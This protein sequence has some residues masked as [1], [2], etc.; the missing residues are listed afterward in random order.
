MCFES[1]GVIYTLALPRSLKFP[2]G[3]FRSSETPG[4]FW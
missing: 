3:L 4:F 2:D 1:A